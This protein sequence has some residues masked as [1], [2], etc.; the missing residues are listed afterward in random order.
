MVVPNK[1]TN[2]AVPVFLPRY[3]QTCLSGDY[4]MKL[5]PK[6]APGIVAIKPFRC[7]SQRCPACARKRG[8]Q[9]FLR[10][11]RAL[12]PRLGWLHA[13]FTLD[14][15]KTG[16]PQV[17]YRDISRAWDRKIRPALSRR[18]GKFTA[19]RVFH[20]HEDGFPHSH[21][22]MRNPALLKESKL[23]PRGLLRDLN[24]LAHRAGLGRVTECERV[25]GIG[26]IASYLIRTSR[27]PGPHYVN[28]P[29]NTRL[30][31]A[32]RGLIPRRRGSGLFTVEV[33]KRHSAG[34][35]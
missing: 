33:V 19:I 28:A 7:L 32:S 15:D 34:S 31:Q 13:V 8:S 29:A 6:A 17:G 2:S 18:F 9:D 21:I 30:I 23:E 4:V 20:E 10:L 12:A 27:E 14:R 25:R 3:V 26:K 11:R 1:K 35:P 16:S 5:H 22:V 24:E